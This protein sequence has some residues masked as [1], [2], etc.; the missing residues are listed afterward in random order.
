MFALFDTAFHR[1]IPDQA[2]LY[3]LPLD[4]ARRHRIRRYGIQGI[5]H[6]YP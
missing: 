4:M 1:S 6:H 2:A 3:P 5:S